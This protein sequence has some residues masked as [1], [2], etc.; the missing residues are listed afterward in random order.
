[1]KTMLASLALIAVAATTHAE[2]FQC[3]PGVFTDKSCAEGTGTIVKEAPT[4]APIK[5]NFIETTSHYTIDAPTLAGVIAVLRMQTWSAQNLSQPPMIKYTI[6]PKGDQCELSAAA[7]TVSNNNHLPTWTHYATA[8]KEAKHNWNVFYESVTTH[9]NG[10]R[11]IAR[12]F[13][14]FLREKL[15]GIGPKPCNELKN[16]L[17]MQETQSWL[18]LR[19]RQ[20]NY[21]YQTQHGIDQQDRR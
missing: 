4:K 10:H 20:K 13:T 7:I 5:I 9:E 12:E 17:E 1:M 2:I 16:L 19:A 11:A 8:S 18:Q 21:D 6:A 14:V 15:N 3:A